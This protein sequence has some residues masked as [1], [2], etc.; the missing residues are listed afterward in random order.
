MASPTSVKGDIAVAHVLSA[1]VRAGKRILIPFS[2]GSRYDLAIDHDGRLERVQCKHGNLNKDTITF[3]VA[4]NDGRSGWRS[5]SSDEI[6]SFGV[7]CPDTER[8]YLVPID[9]CPKTTC[10]LRLK[11]GHNN[12]HPQR[13]A[14]DYEI[15]A[16]VPIKQD[17]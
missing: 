16:D 17:M 13:M 6:D 3:L 7:Y 1:L 15:K 8:C 10:S 4:S 12:G 9:I 11:P 2:E 5:Y 14:E